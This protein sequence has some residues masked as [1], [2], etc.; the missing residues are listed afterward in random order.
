MET[1]AG[2]LILISSDIVH[3]NKF[4][5]YNLSEDLGKLI[6]FEKEEILKGRSTS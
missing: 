6:S 4:C 3:E 1:A 2:V 5:K